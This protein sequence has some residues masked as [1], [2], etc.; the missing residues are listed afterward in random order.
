MRKDVAD[1]IFAN[2]RILRAGKYMPTEALGKIRS[3]V[4]ERFSVSVSESSVEDYSKQTFEK[5][6]EIRRLSNQ[7]KRSKQY[8]RK[9][10]RDYHQTERYKDSMRDYRQT[11]RYKDYRKKYLKDHTKPRNLKYPL[12]IDVFD[13]FDELTSTRVWEIYGG[14]FENV[15]R[16]LN[17]F[18]KSGALKK[19]KKGVNVFYRLN[20]DSPYYVV[21]DGF[22]KEREKE[23]DE[24]FKID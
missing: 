18:K 13:G 5:I 7:S 23:M 11:Q 9:W 12:V 19:R 3:D 6:R 1:Y 16:M 14:R 21:A 4:E 15:V 17:E 20:P 10:L 22:F 2:Y 8:R 24:K